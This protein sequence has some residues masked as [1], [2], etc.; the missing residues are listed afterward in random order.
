MPAHLQVN[1]INTKIRL[2]VKHPNGR[3]VDLT[4]AIESPVTFKRP[5][6]TT[7]TV[8]PSAFQNASGFVDYNTI[9]GD[10]NQAG[11]WEVQTRSLLPSGQWYT[12]RLKFTVLANL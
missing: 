3:P 11:N 12:S 8:T 1:P 2:R 4:T 9:D 7:F 5:D 10:I 6:G